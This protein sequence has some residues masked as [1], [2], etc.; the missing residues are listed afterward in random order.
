METQ[1]ETERQRQRDRGKADRQAHTGGDEN[2][3]V[4]KQ[5]EQGVEGYRER[6][7]GVFRS[8]RGVMRRAF[9]ER[10][11]ELLK[12]AECPYEACLS[13]AAVV[14]RKESFIT[15]SQNA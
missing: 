3:D 12:F 9:Q 14:I 13:T 5:F 8:G 2:R 4:S 15:F 1:R 6:G 11:R 7:R 10:S